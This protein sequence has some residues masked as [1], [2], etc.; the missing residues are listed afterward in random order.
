MGLL[1]TG[2]NP[3]NISNLEG[4]LLGALKLIML[5]GL[6]SNVECYIDCICVCYLLCPLGSKKQ[7]IA[8]HVVYSKH[9]L[10]ATNFI[11]F[12][13]IW[14]QS[15]L[16]CPNFAGLVVISFGP[17]Y[18]YTLLKLLYGARYSDGDAT[19]ILHY[20]CFYIIC[21]AMNG[22]Y[23]L[24]LFTSYIIVE[25]CFCT[26]LLSSCLNYI[27]KKNLKWWTVVDLFELS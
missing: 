7:A 21:L 17:S 26:V 2:Q 25:Q 27:L 13:L 19:V 4:S 11:L 8:V 24:L 20:Y 14:I 3:Q 16:K 5:I 12:V 1:S 15:S 22:L 18:S 9:V 10:V 6:L 23:L